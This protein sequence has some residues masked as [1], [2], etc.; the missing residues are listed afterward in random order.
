MAPTDAP[1]TQVMQK[2]I[3]FDTLTVR[4]ELAFAAALRL[5][6]AWSQKRRAD[7]VQAR[8][9][10]RAIRLQHLLLLDRVDP[11]YAADRGLVELDGTSGLRGAF[12]AGF[13]LLCERR[14]GGVRHR[15]QLRAHL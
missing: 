3:F 10:R 15:R 14:E 5:P 4:E 11:G 7:R 13:E 1:N 12:E 9:L 8:L 6:R 2:D